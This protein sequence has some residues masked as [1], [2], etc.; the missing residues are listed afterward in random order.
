MNKILFSVATTIA[1]VGGTAVAASTTNMVTQVTTTTYKP[2]TPNYMAYPGSPDEVGQSTSKNGTHTSQNTTRTAS[3]EAG[4]KDKQSASQAHTAAT[5]PA[6]PA[7][8]R[9]ISLSLHKGPI[10]RVWAP[11]PGTW[12]NK[13]QYTPAGPSRG[14]V[15]WG[16]HVTTS[17]GARFGYGIMITTKNGTP[18]LIAQGPLAHNGDM[19]NPATSFV[20]TTLAGGQSALITA[21]N[22]YDPVSGNTGFTLLVPDGSSSSVWITLRV[23]Q[24]QSSIIPVIRNDLRFVR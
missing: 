11:I 12:Y 1:V 15:V 10:T 23:P 3:A 19:S 17:Q 24:S 7:G 5:W 20:S 21:S 9:W 2:G 8:W 6:L 22:H 16:N 4:S 14:I 13:P 18:S